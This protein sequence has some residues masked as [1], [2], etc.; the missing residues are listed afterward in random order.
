MGF[1][2]SWIAPSLGTVLGVCRH[3]I[4]TGAVLAVRN[5]RELGVRIDLSMK[6]NSHT[7]TGTNSRKGH[8]G[9][10]AGLGLDT[11]VPDRRISI[12]C[13]LQLRF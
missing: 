6:R 10:T 1:P 13:H 11:F 4:A 2:T 3:F 9:L 8:N 5:K 7:A 12:H